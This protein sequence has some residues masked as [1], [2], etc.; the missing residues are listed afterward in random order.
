MPAGRPL[1]YTKAVADKLCG[2]IVLG[3]SLR[4]VCE[5]EDM[6]CPATVYNWF[7]KYPE[8]L[9][10]YERAKDDSAHSD[11]DKLD[12]I[13][14]KVLTGEYEPQAAKVA[15]DIIKWSASRKKPKKYGDRVDHSHSGSVNLSVNG[16]LGDV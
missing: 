15:A 7:S 4:K 10:Q 3:N 9:K 1:E 2:Q 11:A 5:G 14:E 8:F 16:K 12:N 13:A 6:P